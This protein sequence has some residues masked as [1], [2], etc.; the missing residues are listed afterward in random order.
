L[1]DVANQLP[2]INSERFASKRVYPW[3]G[4]APYRSSAIL[5]RIQS[6]PDTIGVKIEK[7]ILFLSYIHKSEATEQKTMPAVIRAVR[8]TK[9][10]GRDFNRFLNALYN[11]LS[12]H[13]QHILGSLSSVT[14]LTFGDCLFDN[15]ASRPLQLNN[16]HLHKALKV[17]S[18]ELGA[19]FVGTLPWNET[20]SQFA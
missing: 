10:S 4:Q 11:P 19:R 13:L 3:N 14:G 20:D 2:W 6:P 17:C 16:L 1:D 9:A 18:H 8:S 15:D 12:H 7:D 5:E